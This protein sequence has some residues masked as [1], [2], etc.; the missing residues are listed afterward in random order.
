V[1]D[2]QH[3]PV[4]HLEIFKGREL[5]AG[6]E[7]EGIWRYSFFDQSVHQVDA[8]R[9]FQ[10]S[11]I[12]DLHKDIEGNIW[13]IS[14]TH[15][16]CHANRQFEFV[17]TPFENVQA[18]LSDQ[19]SNLWVGTDKGVFT[20]HLDEHGNSFF[21]Q[22]LGHMKL[23]VIS[24]YEDKFQN[25]W[26]GT[27]GEGVYLLKPATGQVRHLTGRDGLPNG[28]ILSMAGV[29]EK[30]WLATLGGAVEFEIKKD[31]L[32]LKEIPHRALN[33]EDGLGANFIYKV[34]IDSKGRTWFGTDG[35][36][37]TVLDNG[38][39]TNYTHAR[40]RHPSEAPFNERTDAK[41]RPTNRG[42]LLTANLEKMED[43]PLKAIY[44]ITEDRMGNIWLSTAKEGIFRFDGKNFHHLTVKEGIRNLAITSLIT[45]EKGEIL[46]V[47]P[48]GIDLLTP[49]TGH[50]IYYDKEVGIENMEPN[51]NAVCSDRQGNIWIG[52][53][54]S[55]IRYT[56]LREKLSIHPRTLL[57][58]ISVFLENI[59]FRNKTTFAPDENNLVFNYTTRSPMSRW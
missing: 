33:R 53:Q 42:Q 17:N 54:Q 30:V 10:S 37:I 36:G 12:Y 20:Q 46:I 27:F 1:E 44:S 16:I 31:P 38:N 41:G 2:W 32:L 28:S 11:K 39:I 49:E 48:T 13:V 34:F 18:L 15:G 6:T 3:G 56:P 9:D 45:T 50:L 58:S 21:R 7:G 4:S 25:I 5:W 26:I 8:G 55:I 59:D 47:H 35:S 22:H 43:V 57:T 23:N 52:S 14:N 51:L 24:L 19:K 40:H 29:N